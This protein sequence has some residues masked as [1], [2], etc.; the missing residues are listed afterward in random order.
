VFKCGE[1]EY[2]GEE[3]GRGD[4]MRWKHFDVFAVPEELA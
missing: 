1:T 3:L 2:R 4:L